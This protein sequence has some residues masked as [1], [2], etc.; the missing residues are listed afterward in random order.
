MISDISLLAVSVFAFLY[1]LWKV[2]LNCGG[3]EILPYF[4]ANKLACHG[5]VDSGRRNKTPESEINKRLY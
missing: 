1:K 5:F 2:V 4:H 3:P